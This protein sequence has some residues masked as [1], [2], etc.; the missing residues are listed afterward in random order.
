MR[1]AFIL[2]YLLGFFVFA[3]IAA[4]HFYRLHKQGKLFKKEAKQSNDNEEFRYPDSSDI[5]PGGG[6]LSEENKPAYE[7]IKDGDFSLV[8]VKTG[9]PVSTEDYSPGFLLFGHY[10]ETYT[11]LAIGVLTKQLQDGCEEGKWGVVYF[12]GPDDNYVPD[13]VDS[14]FYKN[15]YLVDGAHEVLNDKVGPDPFRVDFDSDGQV[16]KIVEGFFCTVDVWRS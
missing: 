4:I 15:I 11:A 8:S 5:P 10:Y 2:I 1:L 3:I 14:W 7:A 13:K 9:E 12:R 16:T 6:V